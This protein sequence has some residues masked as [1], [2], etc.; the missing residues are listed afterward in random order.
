MDQ[1]KVEVNA[2]GTVDDPNENLKKENPC[3][4][5]C[6]KDREQEK[7]NLL[8]QE[9]IYLLEGY[10]RVLQNLED[11]TKSKDFKNL[12]SIK[13]IKLKIVDLIRSKL[14]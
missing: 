10:I 8:E 4:C 2:T 6:E 3:N 9:Q 13:D 12:V 5:D 1:T 7:K 11:L 14:V